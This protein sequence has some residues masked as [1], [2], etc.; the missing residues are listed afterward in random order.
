MFTGLIRELGKVESFSGGF[1]KVKAR[2][3]A[4]MG[5]SIAVNGACL[6]VV[7]HDDSSFTVELSHESKEVLAVENYSG[8]VH[9]EPAMRLSDRVEGHIVQG[10]VDCVGEIL[11]VD[12]SK[13]SWD[14]YITIPEEFMKYVVPKGSITVDGISLT[15]NDV[16]K[17]RFRLTLIPHSLENTLFLNYEARR[18]VNIE[19]DMFA[20]YIY[21]MFKKKDKSLSWDEVDRISSLY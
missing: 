17:D 4:G 8:K 21:Y 12:K 19:T 9:I 3:K 7:A 16:E 5:D 13:S 2:H 10:H 18:R 1:L 14:F 11:K 6:T 20:R 15:V